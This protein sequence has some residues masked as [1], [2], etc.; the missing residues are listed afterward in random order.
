MQTSF[1]TKKAVVFSY[2]VHLMNTPVFF[3]ILE[4]RC[5]QRWELDLHLEKRKSFRKHWNCLV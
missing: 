3:R 2:T 5:W 1:I 4:F